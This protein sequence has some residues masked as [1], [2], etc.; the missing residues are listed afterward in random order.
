MLLPAHTMHTELK[1][2]TLPMQEQ[3]LVDV[4]DRIVKVRVA[5]MC[6]HVFACVRC[7]WSHAL[8]IVYTHTHWHTCARDYDARV[9]HVQAN[10]GIVDAAQ[11]YGRKEAAAEA[12][13][14]RRE[15]ERAR[16]EA[17]LAHQEAELARQDA[18]RVT[19]A[20]D[21]LINLMQGK[22]KRLP[23]PLICAVMLFTGSR[24]YGA[25]CML[26]AAIVLFYVSSLTHATSS[27]VY[28]HARNVRMFV[29]AGA[30]A[31]KETMKKN[32]APSPQPPGA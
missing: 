7:M 14:W 11:Q 10:E 24:V 28:I 29:L 25:F 19:K 31:H 4:M 5:C 12:D 21:D 23:S 30:V 15:A 17:Q 26:H 20:Y 2:A 6:L 22:C 8:V 32:A 18:E 13:A 1:Q 9:S 27:L 16:Q 3:C